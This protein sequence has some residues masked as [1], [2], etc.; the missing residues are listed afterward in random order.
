MTPLLA[1][2][3]SFRIHAEENEEQQCES[4]QRGTAIGEEGQGNAY[5]GG[6]AKHHPHIDEQVE[7]ENADDTIAIDTP[8]RV[9]LSFGQ[10]YESPNEE[11]IYNEH[12]SS[13]YK[14]FFFAH[15]AEDEV[16]VL[17]RHVSQFCLGA[18]EESLSKQSSRADGNFCLIDV[19][20]SASWVVFDAKKHLDTSPLVV[21]QVV[22]DGAAQIVKRCGCDGKERD[23][24]IAVELCV[25][26]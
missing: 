19:V 2:E 22:E 5:D 12:S 9:G 3:V 24:N 25:E 15:R 18:I 4:P 10:D 23:E 20:A 17:L 1:F 16:S 14:P 8:H 7:E 21:S 13:T 11:Q 6:E 26:G